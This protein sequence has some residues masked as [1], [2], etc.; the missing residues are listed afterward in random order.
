MSWQW[1]ARVGA[2]VVLAGGCLI[3]PSGERAMAKSDFTAKPFMGWSSWSVQ[4]SSRPTY[5]T[6]WLKETNLRNAADAL[7]TKLKPAGYEYLNIDAGWNATFDWNFHSDANGIPNPDSGRFPSGLQSLIDYVH[8]KGLKLGLYGAAGLEKEVY[9]SNKPILGTSCTA[10]QIA[11]QPLT[12]TN[13]WGTNWKIDYAHPCAQ[14]YIDS[15]A[16]RFAQWGVDF[17]K[18]DGV[19]VDNVPDIRAWSN[20]ID[21][22]GR[23]MWLTAS[24]WPVDRAAGPGLQPYANSVRIDTDVEC[25]CET[26]A[27]WTSSIDD[28]WQDLPNWLSDVRPNYWPD[29][30]SMPI[31]NNQGQAIQDGINDV[32]RQ[33][34]M[35]FWSMT[36]APLYVGG[37]IYFLDATAQAILTNPEVIAVD[38]AGV[39]P[40][41]TAG[42]TLQRWR[43]QLPSG[44]W[45][46]AVYNLGGSPANITVPWTDFGGSGSR[47]VRDLAARADL[48]TFSGSWTATNVPAHGS[49]LIKLS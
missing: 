15:I 5:G 24:A 37:D 6:G 28:R 33:S 8:G 46:I 45:V 3:G 20:A 38:Q 42:G 31:S 4:S 29:L 26:V 12:P 47:R 16:N 18:I 23:R 30:D 22:T 35:T 11:V 48:G 25:Y 9:D 2:V 1:V 7:A 44:E 36:S 43:K 10:Q 49:R 13:K 40:T 41:R 39:L 34:V 27:T 19:T 14:Q 32:E 17:V 21:Q